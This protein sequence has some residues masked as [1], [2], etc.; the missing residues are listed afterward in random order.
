MNC[1]KFCRYL[2]GSLLVA[3]LMSCGNFLEE[4]SYDLVTPVTT[5]HYKE[6]LQGEGYFR[7]VFRHGW[8][9]EAMTDNFEVLNG[10]GAFINERA[11]Q[12]SQA[13]KWQADLELLSE[14]Q[15]F[16]DNF[17]MHMYRN[18]FVA[19]TC[20]LAL[21]KS[22]GKPE[23]KAVLRGQALFTRAY[24]YFCLAN[25]YAQAYNEASPDELCVPLVMESTPTTKK[26]TRATIKDVWSL[27]KNDIQQSVENLKDSEISSIYEINYRAALLL[28]SRIS[29]FMEDY[30]SVIQYGEKYLA[31]SSNLYD[32]SGI[33]Q[34][35]TRF[36]P[37]SVSPFLSFPSN[38]EI[39]FSFGVNNNSNYETCFIPTMNYYGSI[40]VMSG[41][42]KELLTLY[43]ENDKRSLWFTLKGPM[44]R[45]SNPMAVPLKFISTMSGDLRTQNMRTAEVY[46]NLSEAYL[47]GNHDQ[48]RCLNMLNQLRK[49]RIANYVELTLSN[50][51]TESSLLD[52]LKNERRR[53]LCFEEFHRWWDLRRQGQPEII[54]N[55]LDKERYVLHNKDLGYILNFPKKELEF[56]DELLKQQNIRPERVPER[57]TQN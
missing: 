25:L 45:Y 50:F 19:N 38:V 5:E 41:A 49:N 14:N 55:W 26:F 36:D 4:S 48:Q 2:L 12:F 7:D 27:I 40:D 47:L 15:T 54:H 10:T 34:R 18:I 24:A 44:S 17:Y 42:S 22:D 31:L 51:A 56:N 35:P 30:N 20:L 32:I 39:A 37:K 46:L 13:F 23:E 43:T 3:T 52:M 29:L 8:F 6:L 1:I 11:R 33:T 28:A 9:V 16:V 53:E 21:D 57:I